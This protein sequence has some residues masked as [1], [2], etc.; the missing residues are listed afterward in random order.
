M[1]WDLPLPL[2]SNAQTPVFLQIAHAIAEGIRRGRLARGDALPGSR[3]LAT[4]LDVHRNTVLAAYR[5]LQGEGWIVSDAHATRVS[6]ALPDP[7]PRRFAK[8]IAPRIEVPQKLGFD[9]PDRYERWDPQPSKGVLSL[10]RGIPDLRLLP[11]APLGRAWRRALRLHGRT[12]LDYGDPRGEPALRRAL[13]SMLSSL[14]GLAASEDDVVVT[15]GSQM[16]IDLVARALLR[17][18][19]A[20]AVE[21]FGYPPAWGA[22]RQAGARLVPVPIDAHGLDVGALAK[23]VDEHDVRAV[24]VTPHHQFPTTVVLPAAR[25]LALLSLAR[26][27]RIAVI[28]DDYDYEFHYE[29]R[30]VLPL[31]SADDAG[32]VVYVST[33]SKMFAPGLRIGFVVAPKPAQERIVAVRTFTDRQGDRVTERAVADLMEDGEV[34][35]HARKMRRVYRDRRDALIAALRR[36]LDGT[37]SFDLP[38]GGMALW[39]RAHDVDIDEWHARALQRGV[40]FGAGRRFAFDGK[41]RPFMRLVHASHCEDEIRA[42]IDRLASAL[43]TRRKRAT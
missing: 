25:R 19:D 20:V 11:T 37:L 8:A 2:D 16:A 9:L 26:A 39:A 33:L 30:P 35:R 42:A 36:S 38:V 34:Q 23:I 24:Y 14:R 4:T 3:T 22:L 29:G 5:E 12:L 13:A 6:E 1:P 21:S 28:E 10:A 40:D 15:R 17:P 32:V 31:A 27:K 43:P 18:G 7:K 41:S